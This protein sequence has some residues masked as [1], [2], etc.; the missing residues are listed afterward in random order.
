L[1]D[2]ANVLKDLLKVWKANGSKTNKEALTKWWGQINEWK[3]VDCLG[4]KQ[5]GK[6][7]KPQ[8]ALQRLQE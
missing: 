6:I 3:K 2:V 7:I 8:Y 4:F 5:E 1:G